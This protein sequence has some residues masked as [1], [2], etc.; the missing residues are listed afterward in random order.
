MMMFNIF[1][2]SFICK[3]ERIIFNFAKF[4]IEVDLKEK[5][6]EGYPG[7]VY[8]GICRCVYWRSITGALMVFGVLVIL[9]I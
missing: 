6:T 4:K 5:I 8:Q 2:N 3:N 1:S 7:E 9:L